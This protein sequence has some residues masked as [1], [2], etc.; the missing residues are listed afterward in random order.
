[1]RSTDYGW[2]LLSAL[3]WIAAGCGGEGASG[4]LDAQSSACGNGRLDPAEQC[5]GQL[6]GVSS[7]QSLGWTAGV[8]TCTDQCTY[9][10]SG[11]HSCGNGQIDDNEQ[12]D[13]A[14]LNAATCQSLGWEG[15]GDL[16]CA[17]DCT[18]DTSGCLTTDTCSPTGGTLSCGQVVVGSTANAQTTTNILDQYTCPTSPMDAPEIVYQFVP[19]PNN[20]EIVAELSDLTAD[21]DLI[22]L[23]RNEELTCSAMYC[24][25]QSTNPGT[26]DE[27]IEMGINPDLTYYIIVDGRNNAQGSFSLSLQCKEIEICDDNIDNDLDGQ[28][29]CQD[30]DCDGNPLCNIRQI[31]ERF[32]G[33]LTSHRFDLDH[34]T[35]AFVPD[36]ALS[37]T[38]TATDN[39]VHYPHAPGSG[40][41]T[42]TV[43][44][45]SANDAVNIPFSGQTFALFGVPYTSMWVNSNGNITFGA[46]DTDPTPTSIKF[47]LGPPR[48][49]GQ[50]TRF[51]PT[52][53]GVV[54]V[55]TFASGIAVTY[56]QV[57]CGSQG[58]SDCSSQIVLSWNGDIAL[59]NLTH[60]S[61]QTEV[62]ISEGGASQ[63]S[64]TPPEVDLYVAPN[65]VQGYYE[66]FQYP[67]APADTFDL[68]N[69]LITF[70]PDGSAPQGYTYQTQS[71]V[72]AFPFQ[73]GAGNV[74]S[75]VLPLSFVFS[76][77]VVLTAPHSVAFYG[78][79]WTDLWV[80][81]NGTITLGRPP[82][83]SQGDADVHF[84]LPRISGLFGDWDFS[85][86]D[87][88]SYL[89]EFNDAQG[90]VVVVTFIDVP[91][92]DGATASF[93][94]A[95][96]ADGTITLYYNSVNTL[97]G[98]VG[99]S[100]G[101]G[102]WPMPSE[103]NFA[104]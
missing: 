100:S 19:G 8:L 61:D 47:A 90:Y 74:S 57:A 70:T 60:S 46:S 35:V 89:D 54:T 17:T 84:A 92:M 45:A 29:D 33:I 104:P 52:L 91:D 86:P 72:S 40:T 3:L 21:L 83:G 13:G 37:Y 97:G 96:R 78:N 102:G 71:A 67:I 24:P 38:Q 87:A 11:C 12:C 5:D 73:A 94:M 18:F 42:Q 99:I 32:G 27:A 22:V 76:E 43:T 98:L 9:D 15:G 85:G 7:C 66:H 34:T 56:D 6:L 51:D 41:T 64:Q 65:P 69:A 49:A 31:S 1:M 77:Q 75:V 63:L 14:L 58:A 20:Y 80:G 55:D 2:L 28:V 36:G 26:A 82:L 81:R 30:D 62:G 68:N 44:F 79:V 53:G 39:V 93:Q 50:W 95:I 25:A 103:S 59:S 16:T 10:L 48:I 4:D 23:V 101:V 88:L